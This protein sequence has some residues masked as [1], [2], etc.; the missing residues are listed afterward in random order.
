MGSLAIIKNRRSQ[1]APIAPTIAQ[2]M[3]GPRLP[4]ASVGASGLKIEMA[5]VYI[6]Q[7][8]RDKRYYIGST[9]DMKSRLKHHQLGGTP[10]TKRFGKINLVFVQK[11]QT[12][13]EARAIEQKLKRFKRKDFIEKII[14]DG[15]I[16]IRP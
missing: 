16:K 10:T 9:S 7:G 1:N 5:F 14:K 15:Y 2:A 4:T 6:L 11:Y 8:E 12:L 13:Q 3:S